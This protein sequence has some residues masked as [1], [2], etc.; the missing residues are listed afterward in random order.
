M[1]ERR[2]DPEVRQSEVCVHER[3]REL[4]PLMHA[5]FA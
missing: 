5:Y 1:R 2:K 4:V 3:E